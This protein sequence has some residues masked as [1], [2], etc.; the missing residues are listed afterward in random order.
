MRRV[1]ATAATDIAREHSGN[2]GLSL[3]GLAGM[4]EMFSVELTK[5]QRDLVLQGL[6]F[7]RSSMMLDINDLPTSESL[8][9]RSSDCRRVNE[10]TEHINR[11]QVLVHS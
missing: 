3:S 5:E 1:G 8:Q 7:V 10:L 4:N 6:R 11:A 9:E 2:A